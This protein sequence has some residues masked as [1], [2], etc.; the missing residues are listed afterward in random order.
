MR[1]GRTLLLA[2]VLSAGLAF[3]LPAQ[4]DEAGI[5]LGSTPPAATITDLDGKQIDLA[6]YAAKRPLL[7]EFWATW[8]PVCRALEP[9]LAAAHARYGARVQFVAI[10]VAVNETPASVRRHLAGHP[11]P[12]PYLWDTNGNAVRAFDA[13]TTSYIVL[14][15]ADRKVRYTG[16]GVDQDLDAALARIAP[17]N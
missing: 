8:C 4:D 2:V 7:V 9:K 10:A 3:G 6:T 12:Y 13:P 16:V 11:M 17:L 14:L 1:G 5:A 15:D